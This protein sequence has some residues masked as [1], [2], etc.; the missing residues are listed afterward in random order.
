MPSDS[1]FQC[2]HPSTRLVIDEDGH[3]VRVCAEC[4]Q[5]LRVVE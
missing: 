4:G 5:T 1:M 3:S 2:P